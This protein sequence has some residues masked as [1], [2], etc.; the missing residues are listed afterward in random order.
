VICPEY[1]VAIF[2]FKSLA[3]TVKV[4]ASPAAV[5]AGTPAR[6]SWEAPDASTLTEKVFEIDPE[7]N[8]M[9]FDPA[10]FRVAE[11]VLVPEVR[12]LDAGR[13]AAE[14]FELK[15]IRLLNPVA[16]FPASS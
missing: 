4:K 8:V 12:L 7:L 14:S 1:P 6:I 15:E 9:V 2:P 3:V 16:V 10:V 5:E 11:K 13:M